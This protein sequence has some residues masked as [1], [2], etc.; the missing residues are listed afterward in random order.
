[1]KKLIQTVAFLS[2][3]LT[4]GCQS[5]A[6]IQQDPNVIAQE[7]RCEQALE[8]DAVACVPTCLQSI[9]AGPEATAIACAI[10]CGAR[11]ASDALPE[12]SQILAAIIQDSNHPAVVMAANAVRERIRLVRSI[13]AR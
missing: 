11:L 3:I 7:A 1:M 10:A 13:P 6:Q 8:A 9:P 12:C 4:S 2:I 5:C